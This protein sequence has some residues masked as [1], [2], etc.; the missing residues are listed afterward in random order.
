[1]KKPQYLWA[2]ALATLP[3]ATQG[4]SQ[5]VTSIPGS[6]STVNLALTLSKSVLATVPKDAETGKPIKGGEPVISTQVTLTDKKGD[7]ITTYEE[8]SK[9]LTTK[10]STK[11]FLADMV[12]LQI[13]PEAKGW[14]IQKMQET[15]TTEGGLNIGE[16]KFFLA[17]KGATPISLTGI[18]GLDNTLK[19][20]GINLKTVT[21]VTPGIPETPAVPATEDTEE[22]PAVPGTPDVVVN[23]PPSYSEALKFAGSLVL[24][25]GEEDTIS[26]T[27]IYT[28]S[29]KLGKTKA[30]EQ[31]IL[32]GAGKIS[33]LSG[34]SSSNEI[35]EG[36][37]SFANGAAADVSAYPVE[38]EEEVLP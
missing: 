20:S 16:A 10:Y 27:G 2:I 13:I 19:L 6:V 8:V 36:S 23:L 32:S 37:I 29:Q 24:T 9:I 5:E 31:V 28:G 12:E 17:K 35:V 26:A 33:S 3:I 14:T 7:E 25:V 30:K 18:I 38:E 21:K 4:F 15:I 11:E 22:I 34:T 1:M